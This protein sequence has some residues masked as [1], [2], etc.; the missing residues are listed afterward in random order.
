MRANPAPQLA[1]KAAACLALAA[2]ADWFFYGEPLGWQA[3]GYGAALLAVICLLDHSL[4][5]TN[6]GKVCALLLTGLALIMLADPGTLPVTLYCVGLATFLA[7]HKR[8]AI[9]DA[10]QLYK[11]IALLALRIPVQWWRDRSF[12]KRLPQSPK[13]VYPLR[14]ILPLVLGAVFC[15]MFSKANPLIAQFLGQI[16][17]RLYFGGLLSPARWLFWA[18][19]A[20]TLWAL[21]RPRSALAKPVLFSLGHIDLT[22]LIDRRSLVW[23]L[24]LFN[25]IFA[26]Q[27]GLDIAFLWNGAGKPLPDGLTFAEYAHA[28]AYP[29]IVTALLAGAY[30]L[31]TFDDAQARHRTP[32]ATAL[33]VLWVAQ[34]IFLVVSSIDRTLLYVETYSLTR[35]RI[36]ALI[37]MGLVALGLAFITLRICLR[38]SNIWLVNANAVALLFVLYTCCFINFDRMIADFNVRQAAEVTGRGSRLDIGYLNI[39]GDEAIPAMHWFAANARYSPS[40]MQTIGRLAAAHEQNLENSLHN[41]WRTWTWRR[42]QLA[43]L[44]ADEPRAREKPIPGT[45]WTTEE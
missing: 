23:S 20:M 27:N 39:L 12:L 19:V 45:H 28:G 42:Q 11:D 35:L 32:L 10:A 6:A 41:N 1:H 8:R 7:Q 21:F 5:R 37:W 29:L 25:L 15:V 26:V 22:T 17:W 36:A 14:L 13:P 3:G 4:L 2:G 30:V 38:R 31:V 18:A 33:V 34:N 44:L 9:S 43:D 40:R 16:D 24:A